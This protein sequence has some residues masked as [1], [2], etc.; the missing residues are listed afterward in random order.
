MTD[1]FQRIAVCCACRIVDRRGNIESW[2]NLVM[3]H[4]KYRDRYRN[5]PERGQKKNKQRRKYITYVCA[6]ANK[7]F[8]AAFIN[9]YEETDGRSK[10]DFPLNGLPG[11]SRELKNSRNK[12]TIRVSLAHSISY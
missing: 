1:I 10:R 12:I 11:F 8:R 4:Y 6:R 2:H 3:G 9:T 7:I 5:F